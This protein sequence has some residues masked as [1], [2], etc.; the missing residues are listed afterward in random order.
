VR[1][2]TEFL[3][4][5]AFSTIFAT[6]SAGGS[7][8]TSCAH[9]AGIAGLNALGIP[10]VAVLSSAIQLGERPPPLELAGMFAV[11]AA[12]ALLAWLGINRGRPSA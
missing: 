6:A 1:W 11:V 9:P 5:L 12:L 7:G 8:P 10:V 3:L 4:A 2:N